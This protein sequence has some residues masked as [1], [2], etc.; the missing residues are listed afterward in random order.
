[1]TVRITESAASKFSTI[2]L[3][4]DIFPR[5][6]IAAGGCNG[7]EKRFLTD[8]KNTDDIVIELPNNVFVIID[9]YSYE[10]LDNSVIDYIHGPTGNYFS[11]S[12]PESTSTCGC[13]SSFSL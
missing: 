5:I 4:P 7:F 13:G 2:P 10:M 3:G 12:I 11:I 1:M 9:E 8:T 6:E